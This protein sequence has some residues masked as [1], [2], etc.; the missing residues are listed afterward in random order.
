MARSA[1]RV[2]RKKRGKP[3]PDGAE[4]V[5]MSELAKRSGVPAPTIKHYIREGLLQ[6]PEIRTSKNMAYYDARM[7]GRI[8]VIKE[9]Q[10]E[11]FLPLR[12]I[13]ELLEPAPSDKIR[14]DRDAAQRK[15]LTQ[16]APVVEEKLGNQRRKRSEVMKTFG[17]TK[18]E[19]DSLEKA[20]VLE[21]RGEGETA[22]YSGGDLKLLD[23]LADVRRL[24]L[25]DVFP[26]SV[27]EPY[28]AA[29]RKLVEF[30]IDVFRHRALS[31]QLPA[32]LPD[33]A[34]QAVDLGERLIV[35]LR[36]KLLP[37]MLERLGVM[38]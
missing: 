8:R 19:L 16:L 35:G 11:R 26:I 17:V 31:V 5:K 29:V 1:K 22:G 21:L 34:K 24:G 20:G 15:A 3:P 12:V 18:A 23:I 37:G 38:R 36:A 30:E 2:A 33:V 13:G 4:L 10:A 6:G 28:M 14:A 9:L 7:A 25:G 32:S 27:A